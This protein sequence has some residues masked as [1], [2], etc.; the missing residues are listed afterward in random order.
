MF[1]YIPLYLNV[2]LLIYSF[3]KYIKLVYPPMIFY[4][5]KLVLG[6]LA[7]CTFGFSILM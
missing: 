6:I 3:K 1:L 4:S 5:V 2:P 7:E